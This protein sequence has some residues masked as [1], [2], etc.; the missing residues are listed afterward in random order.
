MKKPSQQNFYQNK[1]FNTNNSV[2]ELAADS[3]FSTNFIF[4]TLANFFSAFG[5]QMVNAILPVY[6]LSIGGN[7]AEA[8]LVVGLLA[9]SALIFRPLFGWV[10]DE[11]KRRPLVLIGNA[12]FGLANIIYAFSGSILTLLFG[13]LVHGFGLSS[14]STATNAYVFSIA[15][16]KRRTE[17]IGLF[18]AARSL[19]ITFGPAVGFFIISIFN[20]HYLFR[21]ATLF[22]LIS[23][24]FTL[25]TKEKLRLP[26]NH[27]RTF[28]LRNGI[29]SIDALPI[30][31]IALCLG[32]AMASINTFVAIYALSK[33]IANPGLYFTV[34]A[35]ALLLS[36]AFSGRL[37]DK[38]GHAAAIIPGIIAISLAISMLLLASNL[39]NFFVCACI[40][41]FGFGM[42]QPATMALLSDYVQP[43]KHGLGLATY[44]MG[45]DGGRFLGSIVFGVVSQI[46]GFGLMWLLSAACAIVGLTGLLWTRHNQV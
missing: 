14:Y 40:I 9:I 36:R 17:T 1:D 41:G 13:R 37:A 43:E 19:G 15:P 10:V 23:I 7:N 11:W 45:Y 26:K 34:Q 46:W 30:A 3:I 35:A 39:L 29:I 22:A 32:L 44:F 25:F 21:L 20:F 8:G 18:A 38:Y 28:S 4:A 16:I 27:H 12:F 24:I 31:W 33:G 6:V 2:N 5:V 42:A